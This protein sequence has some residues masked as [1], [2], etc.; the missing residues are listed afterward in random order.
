MRYHSTMDL[1]RID[2]ET[3]E[4][5]IV[6]S[7]LE[8]DFYKFAMGQFL[9]T[10]KSNLGDKVMEWHFKNRTK[11]VQLEYHI[12][13]ED[14]QNEYKHV[15]NLKAD[16]SELHYLRGTN[17]YESRMFSEG[18][19][20]HLAN[21]QIPAVN[22]GTHEFQPVINPKGK[23]L[24][25]MHAEMPT[26]RIINGLFYRNQMKKMS[27][28]EREMIYMEGVK[29]LHFFITEIKKHPYIRFSDFGN[30]RAFSTPWHEYV[31]ER[32]TEELPGQFIGTSNVYLANKFGLTPIGTCAHELSMGMNALA[33]DGTKQSL[34]NSNIELHQLWW[35]QYGQGLSISLPD[36]LGTKWTLENLS[37]ET[38]RDWKG[39]RLDSMDPMQAIPLFIEKYESLGI[40]PRKKL[41]IPSDGL[42][43]KSTI[44]I[45]NR[46]HEK[47]DLSFGIGTHLTNNLGLQTLSI[48]MK[49]YALDGKACVKLSDNLAKA[50][51]DLQ[52][53]NDYKKALGYDVTFSE[54]PTV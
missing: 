54:S 16:K 39:S 36:T 46:F 2:E 51:G 7:L 53:V 17:E 37:D 27:R 21:L 35:R 49:P 41:L 12:S 24:H 5:P 8:D 18:Y 1:R 13:E 6:R 42:D 38:F 50:T 10:H 3:M 47:I 31:V 52:T 11:S 34:I 15:V 44:T 45:A 43:I 20:E 25:S 14:F 9:F 33:F 22:F 28:I 26:L 23:W 4:A 30:R 40:D 32:L 19:L 29:R 48:V